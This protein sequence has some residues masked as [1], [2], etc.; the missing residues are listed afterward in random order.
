MFG[1]TVDAA[2]DEAARAAKNGAAAQS[3]ARLVLAKYLGKDAAKTK[4]IYASPIAGTVG[5]HGG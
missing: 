4:G 1:S 2:I 3:A 5:S